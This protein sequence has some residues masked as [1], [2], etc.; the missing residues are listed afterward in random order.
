MSEEYYS[1]S[2]EIQVIDGNALATL[3]KAS[4]DM[5]I[6]TAKQYPRSMSTFIKRA[7]DLACIDERTAG[8]CIYNKPVGKDKQGRQQY[9][10]GMSIRMAEIVASCYG[11]FRAGA[12]IISQTPKQVVA[13]GI[14]YDLESNV[15]MTAEVVVPTVYSNGTPMKDSQAALLAQGAL[16]KAMRNAIFRVIPKAVA[17]PVEDAVRELLVGNAKSLSQTR[18]DLEKW[19][20]SL[21][22]DPYRVWHALGGEGLE[23]LGSKEILTL[24]GIATAIKNGDTLIDDAFPEIQTDKTAI[25][26]DAQPAAIATDPAAEYKAKRTRKPSEKKTIDVEPVEPM[27]DDGKTAKMQEVE[28]WVQDGCEIPADYESAIQM[29]QNFVDAGTLKA[30]WL[31]DAQEVVRQVARKNGIR[32]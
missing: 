5:Q 21:G 19:V 32:L 15:C 6:A 28:K 25:A 10:D 24:R 23:D 27:Q 13:Q 4:I 31:K 9:A 17:R 1:D 20:R 3:E 8:E 16:S 11:N 7:C 2:G 29:L 18:A 14:A 30:E 12:R 22:I 26:N